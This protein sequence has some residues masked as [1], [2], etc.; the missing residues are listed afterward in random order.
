MNV[1][2]AKF[3]M[4]LFGLFDE[5]IILTIL[6]HITYINYFVPPLIHLQSIGDFFAP[7]L[8]EQVPASMT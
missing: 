6:A 4:E 1:R 5:K 8:T 7:I 3:P 2:L